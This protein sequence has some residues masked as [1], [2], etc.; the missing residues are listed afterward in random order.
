M[1]LSSII[2]IVV[3]IVVLLI[4]FGTTFG[5]QLQVKAR[6][7]AEQVMRQDAS[8]PEGATDYYN[9]AI[10][11][12]EDA[13]SKVARLYA[14]ISGKLEMAEKDLYEANKDVMRINQQIRKCIDENNDTDAMSY[15]MK[16]TTI[17]KKINILK[18][19]IEDLKKSKE[20]QQE[21]KEQVE[22]ELQKL[23]EEKEQT[24]FQMES[25]SQIIQLHESMDSMVMNNETDRML[26][27]V[28]EGSKKMRE[29]AE[30]SRVAYDSST[31]AAD[32]RLEASERERDARQIV[33]EMKRQRGK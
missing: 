2:F 20:Q 29:R 13:C 26:E 12:K 5:K 27:R 25:D 31:Q 6:G 18:D 7:R 15:A 8:T 14:D 3:V 22:L 9:T 28:R 32:R 10:K 11:E 24:I 4:I 16:K 17:E 1:S 21:I 19:R 23:K 33:E 30:G